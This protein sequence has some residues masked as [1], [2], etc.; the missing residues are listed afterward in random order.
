[1]TTTIGVVQA[2]SVLGDTPR[3]LDKLQQL[4]EACAQR[5]INVAVFHVPIRGGSCIIGPL[6]GVSGRNRFMAR[7]RFS[8]LKSTSPI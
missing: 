7:R 3:T 2:G 6:G 4:C 5:R 8:L 1:M